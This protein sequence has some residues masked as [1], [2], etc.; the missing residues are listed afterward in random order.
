MATTAVLFITGA[1][2][3]QLLTGALIMVVAVPITGVPAAT[4]MPVAGF[5]RVL[6][7]TVAVAVILVTTTIT[8]T[9]T[10]TIRFYYPRLGFSLGFLPYGYYPFWWGDYSVLL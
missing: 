2:A 1:V 3:M 4:A 5:I 9:I 8:H 10:I 6:T 7:I